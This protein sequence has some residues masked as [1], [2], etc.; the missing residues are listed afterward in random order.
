MKSLDYIINKARDEGRTIAQ[1]DTEHITR[2]CMC[3]LKVIE[4]KG[5]YYILLKKR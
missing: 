5:L 4:K 2:A 1:I 3:K